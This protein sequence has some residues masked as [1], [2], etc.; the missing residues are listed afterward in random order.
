MR[1]ITLLSL[2]R[3]WLVSFVVLLAFISAGASIQKKADWQNDLG[4]EDHIA[5]IVLGRL[6]SN[7]NVDWTRG[8]TFDDSK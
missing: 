1:G 3:V 8:L 5:Y 6:Q 2:R 7:D 4:R